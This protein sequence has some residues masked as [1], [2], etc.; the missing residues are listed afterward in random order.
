MPRCIGSASATGVIASSA[1]TTTSVGHVIAASGRGRVR[2]ADHASSAPEMASAGA[3][4]IISPHCRGHLR[5]RAAEWSARAASAA[6]DLRRRPRPRVRTSSI[7]FRRPSRPSAVS[8]CG[9]VSASTM[10]R[11]AFGRPAAERERDVAAHGQS[12]DDGLL[13]LQP[14]HQS[15]RLVCKVVNRQHPRDRTRRGLGTRCLGLQKGC[16]MRR[17][18]TGSES[19]KSGA[20]IRHPAG[21]RSSCGRHMSALRERVEKDDGP[22]GAGLEVPGRSTV[23]ADADVANHF[24]MIPA[25]RS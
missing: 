9:L 19:S 24:S 10:P 15:R 25:A 20:I 11:E 23:D 17:F 18:R 8:A 21:T 7:I 4:S 1:P 2:P 5:T 13:Q 14:V 12:A 6:S 22:A 16:A 3:D